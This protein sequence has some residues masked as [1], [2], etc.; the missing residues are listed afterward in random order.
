MIQKGKQKNSFSIIVIIIIAVAIIAIGYNKDTYQL[1]AEDVSYYGFV[2]TNASTAE[3]LEDFE[4]LYKILEKNYPF[5]NVNKR[6]NNIDW[7]K[8]K[9]KYEKLIRNTENDAEF[10]VAIHLILSDLNN[11]HASILS[12]DSFKWFYNFYHEIFYQYNA[13]DKLQ[14]F[15]ALTNPNVISRYKVKN[16]N[17]V[18]N[19]VLNDKDNLET[20]IL[21]K[22]EVAYMKIKS[23][24][25][26]TVF[27][28]DHVKIREFLKETESYEKLIIDI[29]GNR[30]GVDK[31]WEDIVQLLIDEPLVAKY[32]SFF[33]DGDRE[34]NDPF[35][36]SRISP[37]TTLDKKILNTFPQ[38]VIDGFDFYNNY[39]IRINPWSISED[40]SEQIKFKGKIY[41]LV[42]SN[43]FSSA[44][45]FASFAK[46]T[47]FATLVGETTGGDRVFEDIPIFHL[48]NTNFVIR[49]PRELSMNIDGTINMET[50]TIPHIKVDSTYNE[51]LSKDECI[52]AVIKDNINQ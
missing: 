38:E 20:K 50:K 41:L 52:R 31:Y 37:T 29:R 26:S 43:V 4:Y 16:I 2:E 45:K 22:D 11:D 18:E 47:G 3:K 12:G 24:A 42:D 6:L 19:K 5:F 39:S 1:V 34:E 25:S 28:N 35:R 51:D 21:K 49:Y 23:M 14:F 40:L 46:D 36:V 32:Y 27:E 13:L 15:E 44:E 9:K 7:L 17:N 33:K 8:N 48:P 30:G 10:F